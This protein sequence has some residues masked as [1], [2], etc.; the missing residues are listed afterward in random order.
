MEADPRLARHLEALEPCR[1]VTSA[2]VEGEL[3]FG[4]LRLPAGRRRR[5]L[6]RAFVRI[7]G[8]LDEVLPITRAVVR[9]YGRL[10]AGLEAQGTPAGENDL[11]IAATALAHRLVLV[12]RDRA[13]RQM[14]GLQ[15]EDWSEA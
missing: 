1:L 7:L 8:S 4:V 12:T 6:A 15:V 11:W 5:A 13:F 3:R 2:V 10:K 9:R 14:P